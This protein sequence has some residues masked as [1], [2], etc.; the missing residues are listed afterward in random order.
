MRLTR[1]AGDNGPLAT[2]RATVTDAIG[3]P[4]TTGPT[5]LRLATR[6]GDH[7]ADHTMTHE[8]D[9]VWAWTPDAGDLTAGVLVATVATTGVTLPSKDSI[10]I[11]VVA[12]LPAPA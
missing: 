1:R 8:G 2:I 6:T 9:G 11:D 7:V 3:A 5:T 4:V 10:V 12:L